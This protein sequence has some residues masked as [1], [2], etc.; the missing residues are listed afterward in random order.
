MPDCV[1]FARIFTIL[2]KECM[3]ARG[4]GIGAHTRDYIF[5]VLDLAAIGF[6]CGFLTWGLGC[7]WGMWSRCDL[8]ALAALLA[9][10]DL[11]PCGTR[12]VNT[13]DGFFLR[14]FFFWPLLMGAA[15]PRGG[16]GVVDAA[17]GGA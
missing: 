17:A 12:A 14:A 2:L 13:C 8:C 10:P 1:R 11:E 5:V 3:A 7:S 15:C 4:W 9:F 6:W 16:V